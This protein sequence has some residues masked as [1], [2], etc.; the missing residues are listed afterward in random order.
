M[1]DMEFTGERMVPQLR[2][3]IGLEHLH[4]YAIAYNLAE[5]LRSRDILDIASGEG[6]GSN[7][8][9]K[10]HNVTGVDIDARSITH[11]KAKYSRPTFLVG[12]ADQIPVGD[13]SIDMVVSFET[14]EHHTKHDEMMQEVKRVLR[15]D[16]VLVISC[17]N[18]KV[19]TDLEG[20]QNPYHPKELY[21]NE[22]EDLL[23][24]FF[25]YI[26][27]YGQRIMTVSTI[28]D[29]D[30]DGSSTLD[31]IS[32][33]EDDGIEKQ[34]DPFITHQYDK[35]MIGVGSDRDHSIDISS[36]FQDRTT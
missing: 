36:V 17:P 29:T 28:W 20:M 9:S 22:F 6:Y 34:I 26:A 11:A 31:G 30:S 7:Y 24:R 12:S 23:G 19:Y 16:G 35:Y 33:R 5:R 10:N 25:S 18:K 32:Y 2:G 27:L 1:S 4:R 3:E 21:R 8:L 13:K 15:P 14:L